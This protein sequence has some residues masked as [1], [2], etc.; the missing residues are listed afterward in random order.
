MDKEGDMDHTLVLNSSFEPV[1]IVHWQKAMQLVF[2]G[3]VEILEVSNREIRTFTQTFRLPSVMRLLR[4]IPITKKKSFV[5][6][7]RTNILLR[8]RHCCQYCGRKRPSNELT[9]DHVVPSTQGGK[10]TW[11]NIV[12]ACIQC[13]QKKGGRTPAEAN[14]KLM[15]KPHQPDWLPS[16]TINFHLQ[17]TPEQWRLYISWQKKT[18]WNQS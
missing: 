4:Y 11:E 5:R 2:Q 3:K 7:S 8:D 16:S 18:A 14:M 6:F 12:T 17:S 1:N 10:R 9:L 13:N 15:S